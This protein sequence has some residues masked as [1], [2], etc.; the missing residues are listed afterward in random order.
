M[1]RDRWALLF[2]LSLAAA[3]CAAPK[4][5]FIEVRFRKETASSANHY[6]VQ[7]QYLSIDLQTSGSA[8]SYV[9]LWLA[10]RGGNQVT[11]KQDRN[12]FDAGGKATVKIAL[13]GPEPLHE[14]L[15]PGCYVLRMESYTSDGTVGGGDSCAVVYGGPG[16][17]SASVQCHLP[18]STGDCL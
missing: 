18:R 15:K 9:T 11:D 16:T 1:S 13:V 4:A 6:R 3:A 7:G 10:D 14:P 5:R 8:T 17:N 12:V 2:V